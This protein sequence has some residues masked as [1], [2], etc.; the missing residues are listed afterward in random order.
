MDLVGNRYGRLIVI[1]EAA[2]R[3]KK[4]Y[5]L[6]LCDCGAEKEIAMSSLRTGLTH[7]C[8]CYRE[9]KVAETSF[10]HGMIETGTYNSWRSM[11]ERCS[12]PT[13]I[14]YYLY[15]E[16][17]ISYPSEWEDFQA[18]LRDMGERPEGMTLDRIDSNGNYSKS[19]CKWSTISEQNLNT[20]LRK[21]N[22]TGVKGVKKESGVYVVTYR[23]IPV[24]RY[25]DLESAKVCRQEYEEGI[26][27]LTVDELETLK[28]RQEVNRI[29]KER[30]RNKV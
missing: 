28:R 13:D 4:R 23:G 2:A 25:K 1:K 22:K 24:G 20:R 15:G 14:H 29:W 3:S 27:E 8:G 26:R 10:K 5:W 7:S 30:T 18:F 11:K 16:R 19:N 9:E 17:G 6:C 12:N 21:D